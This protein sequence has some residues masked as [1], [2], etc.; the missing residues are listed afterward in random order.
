MSGVSRPTVKNVLD[1]SGGCGIDTLDQIAR[2]FGPED[3]PLRAWQML[4][5]DLD[6]ANPPVLSITEAEKDL[7]KSLDALRE[8]LGR[9]AEGPVRE[10]RRSDSVASHPAGPKGGK[11][12][13]QTAKA[14][15]RKTAQK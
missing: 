7:W 3:A 15:R 8:K 9:V 4:V 6:P 5:P 2:C 1:A 12:L 10:A 13:D 14:G 11:T